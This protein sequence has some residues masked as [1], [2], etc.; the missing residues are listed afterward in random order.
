LRGSRLALLSDAKA[1]LREHGAEVEAIPTEGP[2]TA[3]VAARVAVADGVDLVVAAGGDGTINEVAEGLIG[4][5][6]PLGILPA[7][8]ANV[9]A[10][11]MRI[12]L[13]MRRAAEALLSYSQERIS[14][15][16]LVTP[17]E[18]E[19]YF[20]LMAGAGLD[21]HIVYSLNSALKRRMG[22]LAYWLAGFS[23]FGRTLEEFSVRADGVEHRCSFALIAKVRNYGGDLE[24]AREVTLLDDEFEVVLFHGRASWRYVGYLAAVAANQL[25]NM[26]NVTVLRAWEG[27]LLNAPNDRVYLQV[28]GEFAGQL[29]A[30]VEMVPSAIS[31]L[32][33]PEYIAKACGE[34]RT[35]EVRI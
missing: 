14:V 24:I 15:G 27:E 8:T 6:V 19:R 35:A 20:L 11:E 10:C 5:D 7:G 26:K 9:L 23:Q 17:D 18:D 28:D 31:L 34:R 2:R 4:T 29:P 13:S 22:K 1:I 33:S 3:G 21:A 12:P 16:R 25:K 32:M 30:R